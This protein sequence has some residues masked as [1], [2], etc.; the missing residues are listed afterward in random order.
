MGSNVCGTRWAR[1]S[2]RFLLGHV[3]QL[4]QTKQRSLRKTKKK[5]KTVG[6]REKEFQRH[7]RDY[8]WF[9]EIRSSIGS[10][11]GQQWQKFR[12][13]FGDLWRQIIGD[14]VCVWI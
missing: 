7:C 2:R 10:C 11:N 13:T 3:L 6:G 12:L 8:H 4:H 9:G 14:L 1:Q 5:K